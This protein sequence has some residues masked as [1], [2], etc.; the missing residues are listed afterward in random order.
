MNVLL[1]MK[2]QQRY[3]RHL[4][5]SE[6]GI[7]GQKRLKLARILCV[8]AGGLGSPALLYLAAAGVGTIGIMDY[9]KVD[10]SNLQRQILFTNADL[11]VKKVYAAKKRLS[12]LN[13]HIEIIP[14]D[15]GLN[16]ENAIAIIQDYDVVLD[17]TDNF[18]SRYLI[19]DVCVRLEKP[20]VYAS[21]LR[22]EGQCSVF[23]APHHP[24]YCC[25]YSKA[26]ATNSAMNCA[27]S[28][29]VGAIVGILGSIQAM[30]AIKIIL[31]QGE[32]LLGRL[33]LV[34]AMSMSF[35][36]FSIPKQAHCPSCVKREPWQMLVDNIGVCAAL[37]IDPRLRGD[38]INHVAN[39]NNV[40]DINSK[41]DTKNIGYT[42]ISVEKLQ[43]LKQEKANF[44]LLDVREPFEHEICNLGGTLIPLTKLHE[45]MTQL[46]GNQTIIIYCKDDAR[47]IKAAKIL[48]ANGCK[49]IQV[50]QGGILAWIDKIDSSLLR[51]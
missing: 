16:V 11:G 23:W 49:H 19:N 31:Q 51:Y 4:A 47:S 13:P 48:I 12:A 37:K 42:Y 40:A 1:T 9:D 33:L 7:E 15:H 32:A 45:N 43:Q 46:D 5:L 44:L 21:I 6:I 30:E 35:K 38:D 25:L 26:P 36:T 17:C 34:D 29:V 2:E 22:F 24:C 20:M 27:D 18:S 10:I 8:G 3:A 50:L 39:I 41:Y 28:G 14:Y